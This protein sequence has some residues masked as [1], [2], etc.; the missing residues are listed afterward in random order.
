MAKKNNSKKKE[1]KQVVDKP[2][3]GTANQMTK[4]LGKRVRIK[5]KTPRQKEFT[6]LIN[7]KEI[8]L[9]AGPSGTG[10]SYLSIGKG[11]ELV[12]NKSNNYDKLKIVKPAVES[13]EN[14]GFLPGDLFEKLAPHLASSMDIVDKI[15]GEANRK[16]LVEDGVISVE[17]LGFLRGKTLDNTV[18]VVEEAQNCSPEQMKTLLTRIGVNSKYIIS[19]DLD[20]SDRYKQVTQTGLYDI[21]RKHGHMEEIGTFIFEKADIVRNPIIGKLLT[22]YHSTTE[23]MNAPLLPK[24]SSDEEENNE[25]KTLQ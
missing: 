15:V 7:A 23:F 8:I 24:K 2:T 12:Q 3:A 20:Q 22:N 11:L 19:G 5:H 1:T 25:D 14:L 17:P 10:K 6:E 16:K 13:G 4:I 9:A 18:L 21:F